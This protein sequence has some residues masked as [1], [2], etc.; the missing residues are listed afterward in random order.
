[1]A[2]IRN[3][4]VD[5]NK[6][7]TNIDEIIEAVK[8]FEVDLGL[9]DTGILLGKEELLESN[10]LII[11]KILDYNTGYG[12]VLSGDASR[13]EADVRSYVTT[14]QAYMAYFTENVIGRLRVGS[15]NFFNLE[16]KMSRTNLRLIF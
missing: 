7:Y 5:K 9:L 10:N 3:G 14:N 15:I 12:F 8:T 2:I 16:I 11:K 13:L 4:K 6:T 1:M